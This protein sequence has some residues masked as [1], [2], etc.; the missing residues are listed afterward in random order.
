[1]IKVSSFGFGARKEELHSLDQ[2]EEN[3]LVALSRD[4]LSKFSDY[5]LKAQRLQLE[6]KKLSSLLH[7]EVEKNKILSKQLH[8]E[9]SDSVI[10][11]KQF[12]DLEKKYKNM[13]DAVG[14]WREKFNKS[15]HDFLDVKLTRGNYIESV[16]YNKKHKITRIVVSSSLPANY[17]YSEVMQ[18]FEVI[19]P[20]DILPELENIDEYVMESFKIKKNA[21]SWSCVISK[22]IK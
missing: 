2:L 6:N 22:K 19:R 18:A 3:D 4:E 17:S 16:E 9:K 21:Q 10:L 12:V 7:D 20:K 11:A 14:R 1:M 15:R 5:K 13:C 8:D